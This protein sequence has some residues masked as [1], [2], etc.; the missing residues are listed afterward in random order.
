MKLKIFTVLITLFCVAA[1]SFA[2]DIDRRVINQLKAL[3]M[4][5]T[6]DDDGDFKI[7]CDTEN[8]RSQIVWVIS[9]TDSY[10]GAEIREIF[11]FGYDGYIGESLMSY[12]LKESNVNKMG[13]W[14]IN[15]DADLAV[16]TVRVP[17]D[18]DEDTLYAA[19]WMAAYVADELE[20]DFAGVDEW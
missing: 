11:S 19:I 3:D 10:Q 1:V 6:I 9:E 16:F 14:G 4:S 15:D 13:A 7:I 12:M 8:G 18:C 5:Y 2:D 20:D 17:A